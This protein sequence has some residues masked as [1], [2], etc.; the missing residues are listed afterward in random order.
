[1]RIKLWV[2]SL[3]TL[4]I[5]SGFVLAII[6]AI[7][8][9]AGAIHW[10]LIIGIVI[11]Y[12]LLAWLVG[13]WITT[14][15]YRWMYKAKF[16]TIDE[17]PDRELAAF[18]TRICKEQSMRAP[19][20]GIID[21]QN[22]TAFTYGSAAYNARIVYT[23]GLNHFLTKEEV[24]AVIAHEIGHIVHKDFIIMTVAATLLQILY[25]TYVVLTKTRNSRSTLGKRGEKGNGRAALYLI[26]LVSYVFYWIGTYLLLFLSRTREYYADAFSAQVTKN[27]N[28]L[29]SALIKIAYGIA[30]VPDTEKTAHLL[31][32]TRAQGIYDLKA[33]NDVGL[34]YQNANQDKKLLARALTYD[35]VNP[36]AWIEELSSTHPLTGKRIRALCAMSKTPLFDFDRLN[37][38]VDKGRMWRGF[39]TDAIV[40]YSVPIAVLAGVL[41]VMIGALAG[42]SNLVLIAG[43]ITLGIGILA[44]LRVRYRFPL[45]AFDP[46]PVAELMGDLYASPVRGRPVQLTGAAI[47]RGEAGF[48]LGEDMM[49]QDKTGII[50]LNYESIIPL[51][52]NWIFGWKKVE[53]LINKP[54]N[55]TGWF[56]RGATHHLELYRYVC[57]EQTIK[58]WARAWHIIGAAILFAVLSAIVLFLALGM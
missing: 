6:L 57:S 58:S 24:N 11:G 22:P 27:P 12:N 47:G 52:G 55:A 23:A 56:L 54:A 7:A 18:I 39:F 28:L 10:P 16:Y 5:L 25:E 36:W 4:G 19:R 51:I 1:M 45:N 53:A 48:I 15:I 34:V 8:Y 9:V 2:S 26:G 44:Y 13:P 42:W 3:F 38:T 31:N 37:I 30:S 21:D 35:F 29:A 50:Y 49:F 40:Q 41:T 14:L 43:G 20:I 17:L 46:L 32:N 33:A